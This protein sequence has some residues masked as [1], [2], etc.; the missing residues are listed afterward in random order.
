MMLWLVLGLVLAGALLALLQWWA[1]ADTAAAKRGLFWAVIGLCGLIA[2]FFVMRGNGFMAIA[3][4]AFAGWRMFAGRSGL[5]QNGHQ[6]G[7]KQGND[8]RRSSNDTQM[9]RSDALQILELSD[10]ADEAEIQANPR[11]RSAVLRIAERLA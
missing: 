3:P 10:G 7:A 8:N 11:A 1:S 4:F 2:I 5:G 6:H 9:S